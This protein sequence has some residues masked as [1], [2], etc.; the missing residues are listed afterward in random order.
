M[1][2]VSS[3]KKRLHKKNKMASI[4]DGKRLRN[5]YRTH[6]HSFPL[7]FFLIFFILNISKCNGWQSTGTYRHPRYAEFDPPRILPSN[8]FQT[9]KAN[10]TY[11][12][13]CEGSRGVSWRIPETATEELRTRISISH[14][15]QG[16]DGN[17]GNR[18]SAIR[19]SFRSNYRKGR[20]NLSSKLD[21]RSKNDKTYVTVLT[22]QRLTYSD[23]GTFT[24]TYNGTTDLDSIDNSTSVHLYVDD[25]NHLL[26]TTSSFD[27]LHAVQSQTLILPCMPTHPDVNVTLWREGS[28]GAQRVFMNQYISFDPKV[29][30]TFELRNAYIDKI[31]I[32]L[33]VDKNFAMIKKIVLLS[34]N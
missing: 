20:N 14:R 27:F 30:T 32:N 23:T 26:R 16:Q 19:K 4:D 5:K 15:L 10:S 12:V 13:R 25:R 6:F 8:D 18:N 31:M 22:I 24:C 17:M 11:T 2:D 9:V 28:G 29:S 7:S 3:F 33:I 21:Q 34:E 1:L